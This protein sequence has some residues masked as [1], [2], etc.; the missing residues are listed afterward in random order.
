MAALTSYE[1]KVGDLENE[2]GLVIAEIED[3][4]NRLEQLNADKERLQFELEDAAK[5]L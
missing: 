2:L 1:E 3:C 4:M 5:L